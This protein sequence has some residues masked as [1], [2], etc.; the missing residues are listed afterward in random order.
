MNGNLGKRQQ[1]I[2]AW[3][4]KFPNQSA[5]KLAEIAYAT[6]GVPATRSQII[7]I[8]ESLKK[9][10]EKGIVKRAAYFTSEGEYCW[11][12]AG[13]RGI[14]IRAKHAEHARKKKLQSIAI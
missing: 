2:I 13:P 3:L 6:R 1:A 8:Q 12:L 14:R 7:T 5:K 10:A 4:I 9:L 11:T